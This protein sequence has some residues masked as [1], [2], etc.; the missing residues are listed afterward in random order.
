MKKT[1]TSLLV[2]SVA[3]LL[4]SNESVAQVGIGTTTPHS[5]AALEINSANKGLLVPRMSEANRPASPAQGL[6]IYQTDNN[7]GFY[8]YTARHGR[9]LAAC[10]SLPAYMSPGLILPMPM[11]IQLWGLIFSTL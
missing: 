6:L 3:L 4:N 5:S 11:A 10:R 7:P 2:L 1:I 8:V 9:Q